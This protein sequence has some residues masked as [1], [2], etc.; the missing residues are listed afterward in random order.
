MENRCIHE[1]ATGECGYC[2]ETPF[3]LKE[4]VYRTSFGKA[5]HIWNNC[6]YLEDG[7]KFAESK[8]GTATE[9]IAITYSAASL[10]L[11]PCEWCC[12]L[13]YSKGIDLEDCMVNSNGGERTAKIV[14]DR[15][16]G[17]NMREF[18]IY[19][20]ETEEIEIM[21]SRYVTRFK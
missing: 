5:F 12:A 17:R 6:E 19:F 4:V 15:Y 18:Q 14:K 7:Q 21:T 1:M 20:Q 13:Y 16:L 11:Y 2:K 10:N 9:I 8:G 3:G